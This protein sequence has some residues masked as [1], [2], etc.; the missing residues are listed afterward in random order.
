VGKFY[1]FVFNDCFV[2]AKPT[3]DKEVK[4]EDAFY[5]FVSLT[6]WT[7]V[8]SQF[9]PVTWGKHKGTLSPCVRGVCVCGACV[10]GV[11][12]VCGVCVLT[13]R[14]RVR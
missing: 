7:S 12:D 5:Q 2:L 4:P 9:F 6:K 10:C 1:V 13:C 11:C 14:W 8:Q 3:K